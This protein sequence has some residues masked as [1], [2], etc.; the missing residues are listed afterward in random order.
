MLAWRYFHPKKRVPK[1]LQYIEDGDLWRFKLSFSRI[2]NTYLKF[3]DHDFSL[4]SKIAQDMENVKKRKQYVQNGKIILKYEQKLINYMVDNAQKV[5][6]EGYKTLAANLHL[7][8]IRSQLGY[9]LVKKLPPIGIVWGYEKDALV[10]SLR[11]DG[12]VDVAELAK[13]YGGGGHKVAASFMLKKSD[14]LPWK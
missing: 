1:L 5:V 4:W 9:V 6:F 11:S 12:K 10:V 8:Y 14:K 2:I 3:Q 7:P 13:R